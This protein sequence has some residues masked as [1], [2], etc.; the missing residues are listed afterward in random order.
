[1]IRRAIVA[2]AVASLALAAA[3]PAADAATARQATT[4]IARCL[5]YKTHA[6]T[7]TSDHGREGMAR[8]RGAWV[9]LSWSFVTYNG[10]VVGTMTISSGVHG[11]RRAAANRCL[12]PYNGRV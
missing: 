3:A 1:V 9:F 6:R 5:R 11:K 12:R 2:A 7:T 10:R 4:K 8:W